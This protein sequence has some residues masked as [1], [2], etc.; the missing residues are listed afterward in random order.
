[1][2]E[3]FDRPRSHSSPKTVSSA[4]PRDVEDAP[5]LSPLAL[6]SVIFGGF[7]PL[8]SIFC[9]LSIPA[10]LIA[11]VLGHMARHQIRRSN[12]RERGAGLALAGLIC[13]YLTFTGYITFLGFVG[14]SVFTAMQSTSRAKQQ[15]A[16]RT[17][18]AALENVETQTLT[19]N[20]G[21]GQGNTPGARVMAER[22]ATLMEEVHKDAF[23]KTDA[24]FKLSGG[25]YVTWCERREG[26]CAFVVHVP[27]YR[28][29][30]S[31]AKKSLDELAWTAAQLATQGELEPGDRLAVG[32]RGVML[33]GS[34]MV[35]KV[36]SDGTIGPVQ[37]LEAEGSSLYPFFDPENSTPAGSG[38]SPDPDDRPVDYSS[39]ARS[40]PPGPTVP[41]P[42]ELNPP[43][44]P[45]GLT[46]GTGRPIPESPSSIASTT[47]TSTAPES[48]ADPDPE[49]S[50]IPEASPEPAEDLP[51]TEV[52]DPATRLP[53]PSSRRR[54]LTGPNRLA[55]KPGSLRPRPDL[56]RDLSNPPARRFSMPES[57]AEALALLDSEDRL[58]RSLAQSYLM[59]HKPDSPDSETAGKLVDALKK[60]KGAEAYSLTMALDGW[61][62]SD[63]LTD[64]EKLLDSKDTTIHHQLHRVIGKIGTI[65]AAK[66]LAKE[67]NDQQDRFSASIA[68][69]SMGKTAEPAIIP[70][71]ASKNS[72]VCLEA[73][74][75]LQEIGTKKSV[76]G[77]QRLTKSKNILISTTARMALDQVR[78]R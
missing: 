21:K 40:S 64:L 24:K 60:S 34:V 47:T 35:G 63:Q 33:Y 14:V 59:S 49:S 9:I 22:F 43:T 56:T 67:L 41:D 16:P 6:L 45:P 61:V 36:G 73:C 28:R 2:S 7:A 27:E 65:E 23:T 71:L 55:E 72:D 62:T 38:K 13:G 19:D 1:M 31:D 15:E 50:D 69:K 11:V 25:H 77:L 29:F 51:A 3:A 75:I 48:E 52:P 78:G 12:G 20:R 39:V 10:S 68:I 32:L 54:R 4:R 57:T 37:S 76:S 46:P 66:V 42:T 74:R 18:K 26:T 58:T 5:R 53:G 17:A 30:T 44:I 70:L 8:T